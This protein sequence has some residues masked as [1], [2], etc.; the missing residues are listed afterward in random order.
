MGVCVCVCVC[1]CVSLSL[2][3]SLS[4]SLKSQLDSILR[5]FFGCRNSIFLSS[6]FFISD[7]KTH[8]LTLTKIGFFYCPLP[9]YETRMT[10]HTLSLTLTILSPHFFCP[11]VCPFQQGH[12]VHHHC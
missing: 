1:V 9:N 11:T 7:S 8:S 4:L 12:L 10:N 6:P 3:L 2:F 5:P